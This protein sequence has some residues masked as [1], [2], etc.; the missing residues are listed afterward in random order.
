MFD[1]GLPKLS[2]T[3]LR[4]GEEVVAQFNPNELDESVAPQWSR[5]APQS[6]SGD[7]RQFNNTNSYGL[8]LSL[9]FRAYSEQ[10][11][12]DL[13][14]ARRQL[15]SWAYPRRINSAVIGGGPPALLLAWPGMLSITVDLITVRIVH[16]RFNTAAR[17]VSF[18]AECVFEERRDKL[19][20][21]DAVADDTDLRFGEAFADSDLS[22]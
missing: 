1:V 15:L 2:V 3:N 9:Y 17:S 7:I 18:K 10:E 22:S 19:L 12:V 11:L 5:L 14:R 21:S 6:F 4:S 13:H 20:T 16:D 8:K